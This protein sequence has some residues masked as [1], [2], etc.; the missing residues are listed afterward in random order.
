MP[1]N[2]TFPHII[3]ILSLSNLLRITWSNE[4]E[5]MSDEIHFL[6]VFLL[7]K[8]SHRFQIL[9]FIFLSQKNQQKSSPVADWNKVKRREWNG[10]KIGKKK[11]SQFFH[12]WNYSRVRF[13]SFRSF[14]FQHFQALFLSRKNYLRLLDA[15]LERSFYTHNCTIEIS[16][17]DFMMKNFH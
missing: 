10:R 17:I 7:Q 2:E 12:H 1:N 16:D 8:F 9:N 11:V 13:H 3:A 5:R 15:H 14:Y 4:D 6:W